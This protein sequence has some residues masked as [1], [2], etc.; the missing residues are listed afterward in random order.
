MN[1]YKNIAF[2]AIVILVGLTCVS[3]REE[4]LMCQ[5]FKIGTFELKSKEYNLKYIIER[6]NTH[7]IETMYDLKT[8]QQLLKP[9]YFLIEWKSDCEYQLQLDTK[10]TKPEEIGLKA[11]DVEILQNKIVKISGKCS[12]VETSTIINEDQIKTTICKK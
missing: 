10:K 1:K 3:S 6:N 4:G 7:Q 9:A 12:E 8:N 2:L 5:D 11:G